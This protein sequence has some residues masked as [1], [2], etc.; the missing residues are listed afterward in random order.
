[1]DITKLTEKSQQ[2]L[3][4]AQ[5][6]A[7]EKGHSD[8]DAEHLTAALLDDRGG[9]ASRLLEQAH[10]D[11][12]LLRGEME[13]RLD[14]RPRVAGPDATP[15]QVHVTRRL[16][17]VLEK[18]FEEARRLQDDYVS[19]EHLLA[20]LID[21]GVITGVPR[22]KIAE[23]V[24]SVRGNQRATSSAPEAA[25]EALEKYG[26]DLVAEARDGRL[27]PVVGRDTEVRRVIQILSRKTKNHP[28][29]VGDPGVGKT[30]LV[31]GLAQRIDRGAV[32][33]GLRDKT[34]FQL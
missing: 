18:G 7:V 12:G 19:V 4:A 28:V 1:M 10:V 22:E 25:Y 29:L 27:D 24:R 8:V 31:E 15:E 14:R 2:A 16:G 20:A 21:E 33:E 5:S 9:L 11:P 32:P 26:R 34:E 6:H 23:A 3:R 13:A 17:R 30:A